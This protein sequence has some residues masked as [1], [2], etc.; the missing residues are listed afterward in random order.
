[1]VLEQIKSSQD[2]KKLNNDQLDILAFELRKFL[3]DNISKTGGHLSSNLGAVELT[4]AIHRVF[5]PA[6][7]R[8]I[9]DVGHQSYVHKILT[10]RKDDFENIRTLGHISGFPNEKESICDAFN[11]GH[12]STS[13]SAGLGFVYARNYNKE[14]YSVVSVIGDGSLTGGMAYEALNNASTIK[15]NFI[16]V[17]NDNEMSIDKNVGGI[18]KYLAELRTDTKYQ[19]LKEKVVSGLDKVPFGNNINRFIRH[20]KSSVKQLL[21]DGMMFEDM[22]I[23]YLGPVDGHKRKDIERF[24]TEAKKVNGPVLVH[25][26]TKKGKG[27]EA[28][29]KNPEKYHGIAGTN[30][31]S[32]D[33]N[34]ISYTNVFSNT[35]CKLASNNDKIIALTAA[36]ADG[37]GLSEF[38]KRFPD[39]FVDVGI[40]EEHL[41]TFASAISKNNLVPVI[42][43]YSSFLQRGFDQI[44]HDV[45]LTNSHVIFAIDRAGIVGR[46]GATHQGSFDISYL[47]MIPNMTIMA[48]SNAKELEEMLEISINLDGPVAIR[49]PR[50]EAKKVANETYTPVVFNEHEVITKGKDVAI[51]SVGAMY[52][53]VCSLPEELKVKKISASLI[54]LRFIKPLNKEQIINFAKNHKMIVTVEENV[55]NGGVGESISQ[56]ITS[57]NI[58]CKILNIGINDEFIPH[59]SIHELRALA[60]ID[61]DSI[62]EKIIK[63]YKN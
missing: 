39:R 12:S 58:K 38:K 32:K 26:I 5:N 23:K 24:L 6:K 18:P 47:N 41:V 40:A 46:D 55:I 44:I 25:V 13:L 28:A 29:E 62:K 11:T 60:G 14:D 31:C 1:M 35:I 7:D 53:E 34:A 16:I 8:I 20:T 2:L 61:K 30:N 21:I 37:T 59:G 48:P 15:S 22:G 51:L 54:N 4:L 50:G 43:V 27:L 19:N 33:S 45:A 36:M 9:F 17:L 49:Y 42:A 56:I 52:E 10:G 3:V 57:N 63:G